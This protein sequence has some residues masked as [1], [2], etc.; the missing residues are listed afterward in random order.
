MSKVV[1]FWFFWVLIPIT[2]LLIT[3][4]IFTNNSSHWDK[5]NY[6][7]SSRILFS[8]G[9]TIM[10]LVYNI[11]T[12][13]I[14]SY[15]NS[16]FLNDYLSPTLYTKFFHIFKSKKKIISQKIIYFSNDNNIN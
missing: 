6:P 15:L 4:F 1:M 8:R 16:S 12:S 7:E 14:F 5:Y 9:D 13:I 11:I 3:G 2:L 10:C